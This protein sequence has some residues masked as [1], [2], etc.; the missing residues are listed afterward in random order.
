MKKQFLAIALLISIVGNAQTEKDNWLVGGNVGFRTNKNSN[1][2]NLSPNA[3]LFV[4]NNLAIGAGLNISAGKTGTVK[5][6]SVGL[7]PFAR[8]YLG[9]SETVKPFAKLGFDV[10]STKN[11]GVKS[12]G[13]GVNFGMG[14]ASFLNSNVAFEAIALYESTKYK[15]ASSFNGFSLNLG[16]QVYLS[17]RNIKQLKQQ[18]VGGN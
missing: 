2:F 16:F 9:K 11:A 6:S 12:S 1:F 13:T 18:T 7:G 5:Y 8:W 3:G 10:L 14:L 17:K 15:N 4:K